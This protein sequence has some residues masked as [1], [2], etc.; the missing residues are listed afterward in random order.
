MM[1]SLIMTTRRVLRAVGVVLTVVLLGGTR[2]ACAAGSNASAVSTLADELLT[3]L[4]ATST[5][6]RMQS[7]LTI[8]AFDPITLERAQEESGFNRKML[9]RADAIKLGGLPHEQWILAR[10][11]RHQ[12][13]IGVHA[14]EDYWFDFAVTPYSGGSRINGVLDVLSGQRLEA[15]ADLEH[16]LH[17]LD[18]YALMLYQIASKTR[19]QADR[20]IRVARPAI[21]GVVALFRGLKA[22]ATDT[23]IPATARLANVQPEQAQAFGAAVRERVAAHILP[24][25]DAITALFAETYVQRAPEEVGIGRYPG[26]RACYLRLISAHTDLRPTPRAIYDLGLKRTAELEERM[27]A[28]RKQLGFKGSFEAFSAVLRTDPRFIARS[29]E[30]VAQRFRE[31]IAR[32]QPLL[33]AYF[34]TLPKAPYDVRPLPSAEE[35]GMTYGYYREPTALDAM[36]HYYYNGS[37]LDKRSLLTTEHL[38]YHELM[39]GHHLQ[40]GLQLEN[41]NV[42]PVR[43]FL[44]TDAFAEGWAEYAASLGEEMGLYSNPYDM[45]GHL[46]MQSFLTARLVVDTGMNSFGMSLDEARRYMKAHTFESDEQLNSETLRYSTDIYAQALAYRTGYEKMWDLRHQAERALGSHF[47][48]RDFHEAVIGNGSMPLDVLDAHIDWYVEQRL[49]GNHSP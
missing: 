38:I 29:P 4:R 28:I 32:I 31:Y 16:Y 2:L 20:G 6:V 7:G 9:A 44:V 13:E 34:A 1:R 45:Y 11:L 12:F 35:G 30:Q 47:D 8:S 48:I 18:S 22:S 46:L 14:E 15:A 27:A 43:K 49:H 42:N 25:Y 37:D 41:R 26:G 21:P 23:L 5:Y 33:P 19:S 24:A 10:I 36:G 39:P 3:H 17:L 40:M